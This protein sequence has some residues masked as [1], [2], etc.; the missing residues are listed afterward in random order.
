VSRYEEARAEEFRATRLAE[1][2]EA[3]KR[4][5]EDKHPDIR[6]CTATLNA[7]KE[8]MG[9]AFFTASGEDFEFALNTM[10]SQLSRTRV[11]TPEETKSEVIEEILSLLAAHS[12]RDEFMLKSE[13]SR[14]KHMS[15]DALEARLA[16]LKYKIDAVSTPVST[17]KAFVAASRSQ[18]QVKVLPANI[19]REQIHAMPSSEIRKLVREFGASV[20]NNRLFGRD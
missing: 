1:R 18:P 13:E 14:M 19:T 10:H 6:F 7:F 15:L 9:N 12:R 20:V 16:E 11:P 2:T 17:L 3:L 5:L 4:W 8:D